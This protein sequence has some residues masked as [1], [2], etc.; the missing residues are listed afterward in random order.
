[1][2]STLPRRLLVTPAVV[3]VA[4]T[5][6]ADPVI[7]LWEIAAASLAVLATLAAHAAILDR[8]KHVRLAVAVAVA[9][10]V[11]AGAVAATLLFT[12]FS[13]APL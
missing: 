13:P 3:L 10:A 4:A 8:R 9:L 2:V 1:M 5:A 6:H 11:A 7:H 12:R